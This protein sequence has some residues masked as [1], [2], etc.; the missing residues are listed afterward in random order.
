MARRRHLSAGCILKSEVRA[1]ESASTFLAST[2]SA[3]ISGS[4]I[5]VDGGRRSVITPGENRNFKRPFDVE[6]E[7]PSGRLKG[8]S[9]ILFGHKKTDT[10]AG[11]RWGVI[12]N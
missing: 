6:C 12:V 7:V 5:T 3:C 9:S 8:L 11:L 1:R 10:V 4:V 2:E